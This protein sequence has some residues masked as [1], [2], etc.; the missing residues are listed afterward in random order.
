M[1]GAYMNNKHII[2]A[3]IVAPILALG[4]YFIADFF[5]AEQPQQAR[6]G[7]QY[8]LLPLPNCRYASGLCG[9]KNGNF[10]VVI[11]GAADRSGNVLLQ[12]DSV[13]ALDEAYIAVVNDSSDSAGPVAMEKFSDDAR[14]WRLSVSSVDPLQQYLRLAV[15]AQGAVYYAE[16]AM[17]FLEY[18]T[19]FKKDFRSRD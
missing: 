5:I 7:G 13:F 19:S 15:T 12:L 16:T 9:L 18:E 1:L 4:G 3:L 10:K 8:Q 2:T 6:A 14:V 17:P 11:T